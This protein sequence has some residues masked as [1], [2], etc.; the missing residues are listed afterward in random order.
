MFQFASRFKL[1]FKQFSPPAQAASRAL[2]L[3]VLMINCCIAETSWAQ[4]GNLGEPAEGNKRGKLVGKPNVLLILVDDLKPAL[5]C[6][7]DKIAQTPNINALANAGMRFDYA[8]CNQAVCAPSR[9]T[10]MLGSHSTSTGLYGLGNNLR[11]QLPDAITLPQYF[12]A[13]GY[14]TESLGKVFHVGHGN[15][16]DPASFSVPHFKDK[17]IEY[18]E[19]ESTDGGQL[20]REE[21]LF[22]NQ[23]L[24]NI[25]QLPRGA[26][27]EDPV[28]EDTDY[29]D[30][31][32]AVETI[33]R[34]QAAKLRRADEGTPFFIAA[35]FVRPHLPF[36]A[37]KKYWDLYDPAILPMPTTDTAPTDAPEVALKKGGEITAYKPV[38]TDGI[39]DD[40]L[41]RELIHG[42]YASMS[43]V[44]A[45]I[46]KVL[47]ELRRLELDENTV[48]VL[49]GDHGFHLG[50]LGIWTKHTNYEQANRIPIIIAAPGVTAPGSST[51]QLTESADIYPTL[52]DLAGLPAPQKTVPQRLDGMS[53]VPVLKDPSAR[54]R[55]FAY[56]A[57]PKRLLGR[58][59]RTERYR[60]VEWRSFDGSDDSLQFELYDY[61]NDPLET[62]NLAAKQPSVVES[63]RQNL[64]GREFVPRNG[65]ALLSAAASAPVS[66]PVEIISPEISAV[67]I[68]V[69]AQVQLSASDQTGVI[70][71][72]GGREAGYALHVID[73]KPA[74]D[75]RLL[76]QVTRVISDAALGD[77]EAE[78]VAELS[79]STLRLSVNGKVVAESKSPGLLDRQPKDD[80]SIG[81]DE[82]SAAGDYLAPN[83]LNDAKLKVNVRTG[84]DHED[85]AVEIAEPLPLDAIRAGLQSHDRALFVMNDWIRDPYI[86]LGPDGYF[87]LTGTTPNPDD[88]RETSDPYNTGLGDESIVGWKAKIWR[89]RDLAKWESL[90]T[91]FTLKDG[92]WF[93]A[94]REAFS[95]TPENEWRLWA[96]ELHWLGDRWALV[97]TSPSPVKGA[98]LSLSSGTSLSGGSDAIA[99][100]NPM[101]T[102][103]N[104]KHDPSLFQDDDGSWWMIWGATTI[105][106]L[107]PDF[108][109]FSSEPVNIRPGGESSKMGHEGCL[110]Q[111]IHGKYVLFGTGWSTGKM[112]QGSY[113]LYYA[114]ADEISGPYSE[115]KFVG[116]FLGHGTPFRD[117]QGR[118]WCTA[119]YN[120]NVPPVDVTNIAN[121]DLGETAQ[122]INQRGTTLVPLEVS[123][124]GSGELLIR[125]KDPAYAAPGPDELQKF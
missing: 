23:Q 27:F 13:H 36:S 10:L 86:I 74:F 109:G 58:A 41:A 125:A 12:A 89:S 16:G 5:G 24:G 14:R 94:Q 7:G 80:L 100:T 21:A 56:H 18:L 20:T 63:L 26:A 2:W 37:P 19:P 38:P 79:E 33:R 25:R 85:S 103:I 30:G 55:E 87:Y 72:Q 67:P 81:M 115:R 57:Y 124:A 111:K 35:G 50:D 119:F 84:G 118:W 53:L 48:V 104:K 108:S 114:V 3:A 91:P 65:K 83:P 97:Q 106:K 76:G 110:I 34:L 42:Y 60:M 98:N 15:E 49:W 116:R 71:A 90:G 8:Y 93:E 45:Q 17:V 70:A 105:A 6:Y 28:A 61:Q 112:R 117:K 88:P 82:R 92:I 52:V 9:F 107:K 75:V 44:D 46:G 54:V 31:R 120:G 64:A 101:G 40:A 78:I 51:R 73:G 62:E 11:D 95:G 43:Y 77:E 66:S 4:Q 121:R 96:P 69:T 47:D 32:V 59:I 102:D 22:T 123:I 99:W 29:A 113:N 122:T 68:T 39:V 1:T